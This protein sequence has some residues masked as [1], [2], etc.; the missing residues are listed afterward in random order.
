MRDF[1][2]PGKSTQGS[3]SV[4]HILGLTASPI[5]RSKI[6]EL[7]YVTLCPLY[8]PSILTSCS[9]IETNLDSISQTPRL[10]RQEMLRY[11]HRPL[12]RKLLYS[13]R[14]SNDS[15]STSVALHL[16]GSLCQATF[17]ENNISLSASPSSQ[18]LRGS[19]RNIPWTDQLHKFYH[20]SVHI[21]GELGPWAADYFIMESIAILRSSIHPESSFALGMK[22]DEKAVLLQALDP[23]VASMD[24]ITPDVEMDLSLSAKLIRLISFLG[25]QNHQQCS[26]LVFV[27]QRATVAV[28]SKL[29]SIHPET[30]DRFRCA[31]FVGLSNSAKRKYTMAE[32]LDL[33]AQHETL[34][35]FKLGEK[36]LI[37]A[38]DVLEE[39]IDVTACN[40]VI[41]FDPP[42]NLKSF[43]QRRGRA[44]KE[45]STFAI[46]VAEADNTAAKIKSWQDLEEE[47]IRTYQNE[48][49]SLH[50]VNEIEQVAE[51]VEGEIVVPSTG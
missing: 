10:H 20:K 16:L 32:M 45:K 27:R 7:R 19:S 34:A 18:K 35:Q 4:P 39:G 24:S 43:V 47:M 9:L 38:T 41:C 26:G 50:G 48:M 36:N 42:P 11:V 8:A 15:V 12:L 28:L 2:H 51:D 25:E 21:N 5:M 29:L 33:K 40:L 31:T 3:H 44:R 13:E 30:R 49:R 23:V 1:Y 6:S 17:A 37:I 22:E 46:M 14:D